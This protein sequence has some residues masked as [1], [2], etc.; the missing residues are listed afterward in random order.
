MLP[1]IYKVVATTTAAGIVLASAAAAPIFAETA[2]MAPN[3]QVVL[4][5]EWKVLKPGASRPV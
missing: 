5:S 2:T 3:A 1:S 4:A